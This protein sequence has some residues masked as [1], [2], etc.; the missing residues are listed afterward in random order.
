[1]YIYILYVQ[2]SGCTSLP[3]ERTAPSPKGCPESS[4]RMLNCVRHFADDHPMSILLT[5]S[6]HLPAPSRISLCRTLAIYEAM[7]MM[8][9][10]NNHN[11]F[12][13]CAPRPPHTGTVTLLWY[14]GYSLY[15]VFP[16]QALPR[17]NEMATCSAWT[18]L[19]VGS[20]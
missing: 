5:G 17:Q 2:K 14:P 10:E 11:T 15:S 9:R 6:L 19:Q 12:C 3:A 16:P 20:S 13:S 4:E 7:H 1:M 18:L 8:L